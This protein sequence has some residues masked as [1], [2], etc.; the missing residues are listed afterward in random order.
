[1]VRLVSWMKWAGSGLRNFTRYPAYSLLWTCGNAQRTPPSSGLFREALLKGTTAFFRPA[2]KAMRRRHAANLPDL[3]FG[4]EEAVAATRERNR[5]LELLAGKIHFGAGGT[6]PHKGALSPG[7]VICQDGGW[8]CNF[9]NRLCTRDCFFCKR[10]HAPKTELD[11]ET[12]GHSF[13]DAKA[14]VEFARCLGIRGVGFS[15]GEPLLVPDRLLSHL[16]AMRK[17]FGNSI[18]LWMYTNGDRVTP[19]L[20]KDLQRAGLNEIR[21]NL[22]ARGYDL[23]PLTVARAHI[24][25]VTVEIPVIPEDFEQLKPLMM[26]LQKVGVDFLNLHQLS[27]EAQNWR[28]L[29]DRPYR[30]DCATGLCVHESELCALRLLLHACENG[31]HLP[32]NYC[33]GI[34]KSRYQKRGY[35]ARRAMAACQPFEELTQTGHLRQ[36][37]VQSS[38]DAIAALAGR[39]SADRV[40]SDRWKIQSDG[41]SLV[42]HSSLMSHVDWQVSR[43]SVQYSEPA[44]ALRKKT[45]GVC[46]TNLKPEHRPVLRVDDVSESV[47]HSL[48]DR[49]L[50]AASSDVSSSIPPGQLLLSRD[51]SLLSKLAVFEELESG[52]PDVC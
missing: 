25:T 1:M 13:P 8:G 9:I 36:L 7:C 46:K 40:Q 42:L 2:I 20:M 47:F 37:E 34:Y 50:L 38:R 17:E 48:R 51:A 43:L 45:R 21:L 49:Y 31:L 39:I 22:A 11:S 29:L 16:Q 23:A 33:S 24:P 30:L 32:V 52:L 10:W 4:N 19:D 5:L 15:G 35:R 14:H 3:W 27:I 28:F 44:L 41:R 26:E 12:E 6:K 18:Y